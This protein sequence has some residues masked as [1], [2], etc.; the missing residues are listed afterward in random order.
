LSVESP[1]LVVD[2]GVVEVGDVVAIVGD[3]GAVVGVVVVGV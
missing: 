2:A 1:E 3:G